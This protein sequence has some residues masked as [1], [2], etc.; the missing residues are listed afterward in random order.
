MV[1]DGLCKIGATSPGDQVQFL[2]SLP[3]SVLSS[4]EADSLQASYQKTLSRTACNKLASLGNLSVLSS[5][6]FA[7]AKLP[8][9]ATVVLGVDINGI[10][11]GVSCLDGLGVGIDGIGGLGSAGD[12]GGISV[13]GVGGLGGVVG[14]ISDGVSGLGGIGGSLGDPFFAIGGTSI[15]RY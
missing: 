6:L 13:G 4:L 11:G 9:N 10:G 1:V 14:G 2:S 3:S 8:M 12:I 5:S 7:T 15:G